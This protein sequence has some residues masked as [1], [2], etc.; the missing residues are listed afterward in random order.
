MSEWS[1]CSEMNFSFGTTSARRSANALYHG[2]RTTHAL[3][4]R[5]EHTV[6]SK[7]CAPEPTWDPA[8][9]GPRCRDPAALYE[10]C[11]LR[12]KAV[13]ADRTGQVIAN[14][15]AAS[16]QSVRDRQQ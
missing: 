10:G 5:A 1:Y 14:M 12:G 8:H 13:G 15:H 2:L 3:V 9:W 4:R 11:S 6:V 16:R 7:G